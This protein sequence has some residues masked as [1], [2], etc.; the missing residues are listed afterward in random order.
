MV[1]DWVIEEL[2]SFALLLLCARLIVTV[3]ADD[4]DDDGVDVW[5]D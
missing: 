4:E 5:C 3:A 2:D 1:G